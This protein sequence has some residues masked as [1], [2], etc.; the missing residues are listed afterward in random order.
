MS[1]C[2]SPGQSPSV[3]GRVDHYD[4]DASIRIVRPPPRIS[5][6]WLVVRIWAAAGSRKVGARQSS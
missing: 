2:P 3:S 1:S 4:A 5:Q 6:V